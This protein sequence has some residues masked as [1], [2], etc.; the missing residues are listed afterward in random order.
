M[1]ALDQ[2][3]ESVCVFECVCSIHSFEGRN[4]EAKKDM[5]CKLVIHKEIAKKLELRNILQINFTS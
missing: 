3:P 4:I 5:Y 2:L 1:F